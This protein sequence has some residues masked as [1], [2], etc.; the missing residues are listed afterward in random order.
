M[1]IYVDRTEDGLL[2]QVDNF[3]TKVVDYPQL[4]LNATKLGDLRKDWTLMKWVVGADDAYS[5]HSTAVNT[6]KNVLRYGGDLGAFPATPTLAATPAITSGGMEKR[7]RNLIQDAVHSGKLTDTIAEALGI[8]AAATAGRGENDKPIFKLAYTSGG[9]PNIIWKKG[10]YD[11]VEIHKSIDGVNFSK[12]DKDYKP[13]YPDKSDLPEAT[14]AEKWF[15]K[16]IYLVND[17]HIGQWSDIQSIA[18]GG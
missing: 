15:Y 16:L 3:L 18:V 7:F 9:H 4:G 6:F 17:E 1:T 12:L 11:G 8:V 13:D 2:T 10:N 5:T 14:K